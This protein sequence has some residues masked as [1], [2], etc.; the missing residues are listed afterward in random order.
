M[1]RFIYSPVRFVS[2]SAL[3]F[4]VCYM[5]HI[6]F[7]LPLSRASLLFVFRA[8]FWADSFATL[9]H[10]AFAFLWQHFRGR[11]YFP[12]SGPANRKFYCSCIRI[13]SPICVS[14]SVCVCVEGER[15]FYLCVFAQSWGG[16]GNEGN[17]GI[18]RHLANILQSQ[19]RT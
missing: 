12:I 6:E 11:N 13:V 10:L 17:R 1:L 15:T 16:E 5:C 4:V 9:Q 7:M 2:F 18:N 19:H 8:H 14:V 3:N